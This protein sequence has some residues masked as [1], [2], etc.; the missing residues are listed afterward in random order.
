VSTIDQALDLVYSF[1]FSG[2]DIRPWQVRSEIKGLLAAIAE[3]RPQRVLEIGTA[4]GG[5]LYLLARVA[6][7]DAVLVSV[8]LPQGDFGGGYPRW[9]APLYRSFASAAQRIELIRGN[10]HA[11]AVLEQVSAAFDYEP[12]DVVF[13]DG[14]H[15]YEGVRADFERYS[16]LVAPGGLIGLHDIVPGSDQV[17]DDRDLCP[18][19]VARFWGEISQGRGVEE[20]VEN[21]EQG[22]FG[23]GVVRV[24]ASVPLEAAP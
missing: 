9:R 17:N 11:D 6:A 21:W 13:I 18:G 16:A 19:D 10:S 2:I 23:I 20:L 22:G 12:I 15:R 1:S 8:D 3:L 4:S 14:D 24:P 5:T 7:P